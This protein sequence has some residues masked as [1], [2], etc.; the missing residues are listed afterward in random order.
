MGILSLGVLFYQILIAAIII[1]AASKGKKSLALAA[2]LAS[3]WTLSHVFYPPL[4]VVQFCTI[5]GSGIY[6]YKKSPS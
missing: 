3:L 4:M 2:G 6:G 1:F 5:I